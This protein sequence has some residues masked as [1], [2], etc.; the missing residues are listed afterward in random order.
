[1]PDA[2]GA[3]W[4]GQVSKTLTNGIKRGVGGELGRGPRG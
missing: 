1:M 3:K 4:D 2:E